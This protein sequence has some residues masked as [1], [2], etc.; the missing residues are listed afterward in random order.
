MSITLFVYGGLVL[1]WDYQLCL[2]LNTKKA[3]YIF[4][5]VRHSRMY[6][7]KIENYEEMKQWL[8]GLNQAFKNRSSEK[9]PYKEVTID[10]IVINGNNIVLGAY[11]ESNK[12]VGG[13]CI[14]YSIE[15]NDV[16]TATTTHQWTMSS[17]KRQGVGSF[18][19]KEAANIAIQD[20]RDL[21]QGNVA[22]AYLPTV[23]M[24]KKN[25]YKAIMIY[26]NIPKTYY[27]I[28]MIKPIGN[29]RF[30]ERKRLFELIKSTVIFKILY[31]K[32][33]SPTI[34]NRMVYGR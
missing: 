23:N 21:I 15:Y 4:K 25:G 27:F 20:G 34:I 17:C 14:Y 6:V 22:S 24:V 12:L 10:E 29:Y 8:E 2:I 28:R 26:A 5:G 9:I 19:L 32:D 3:K 31:K 16:K 11:N 30:S 33:S 13:L 1:S 18:L 7:K